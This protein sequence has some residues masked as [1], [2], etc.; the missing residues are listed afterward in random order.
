MAKTK[1][2]QTKTPALPSDKAHPRLSS[3]AYAARLQPLQYCMRSIALSYVHQGL[4]GIVVVEGCDTAGKGGAIR[5][6]TAELDPRHYV[7]WPIGAPSAEEARHHYLWRFWQRLPGRGRIA[8]FDRSWYGRVLVERVD[9]VTSEARWR[10]AYDEICAFEA[11]LVADG[12]RLVKLYLHVSP[13]EQRAR[14]AERMKDQYKHWKVSAADFR[15]Y[16]LRDRYAAAAAEMFLRTSTR[17]APWHVIAGDDKHYARLVVLETVIDAFGK[18]ID[19]APPPVDAE[20]A[21]LAREVLADP[22]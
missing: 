4:S 17:A 1:R 21:R 3:K 20:T 11:S 18:G 12:T 2:R 16:V 5:R 9:G 8:V 7:V 14:L 10:Q 22:D 13:E 15:A 6:L 19:V